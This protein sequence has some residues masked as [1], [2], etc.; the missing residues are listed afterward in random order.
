MADQR[1]WPLFPVDG[2]EQTGVS[3]HLWSQIVGKTRMT[4]SPPLN[5]YWHVPLYVS[6]HGLTT[7]AIPYHAELFELEFDFLSHQLD[8]RTSWSYSCLV[9]LRPTSVA[10][11]YADIMAALGELGIDVWIE[12]RPVEIADPI[13]FEKDHVQRG[14]DPT[15]AQAFWRLLTQADRVFKTFRGRFLGKSSPVH[16]F[17]GGFDLAVTRFSGR[18]A[19]PHPGGIPHVADWVMREAYSHEESSAGFWTGDARFPRAAFYSYAYPEP[20]G[21]KDASVRP[22]AAGYDPSLGEF[23]LP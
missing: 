6:A 10:E 19:P 1:G 7:S 21:F 8:I 15:A 4:F 13:A 11:M 5:H 18:E 2:W 17:W 9:P 12:T 14:Y 3:L 23:V 22:A 16:F 20:R